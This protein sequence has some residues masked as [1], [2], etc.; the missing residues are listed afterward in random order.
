MTDSLRWITCHDA[1]R[2]NIPT[3]KGH[4]ANQ[5]ILPNSNPRHHDNFG[6]NNREIF[7]GRAYK[8]IRGRRRVVC[9]DCIGK[10]PYITAD[11]SL[12]RYVDV[13]MQSNIVT[14]MAIAFDV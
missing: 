8:L 6:R 3:N 4:G 14:D 12:L 13:A 7:D 1:L 9:K 10:Y 2:G 5:R 11:R